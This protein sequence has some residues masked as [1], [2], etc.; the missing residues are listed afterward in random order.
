MGG[1]MNDPT[2]LALVP[3]RAVLAI[4]DIQERLAAAMDPEALAQV[5]GNVSILVELARRLEIPVVASEQYPKGLGPTREPVERALASLGGGAY[6]LEKVEFSLCG[7]EDF[8]PIWEALGSERTQWI[9]V[10][11]EAHVCVY[12]SARELLSRGVV[13]HIPQDAVI[14]RSDANRRVGTELMAR[15][16]G[17]VTST[18]TLVFDALGR[19]G[20]EDFKAM[21][22]LIR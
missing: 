3:E 15:A 10:G 1:A 19:A 5:E 2:T 16:G 11:M 20:T 12:Q 9:V 17:L 13:T 18:E 8:G 6:R 21:S 14:S 4:V 22:R 7:C